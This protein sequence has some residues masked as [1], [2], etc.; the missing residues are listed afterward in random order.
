MTPYEDRSILGRNPIASLTIA[1]VVFGL[2]GFVLTMTAVGS[3]VGIPMMMVALVCGVA[4]I[5]Q[6]RKRSPSQ[7]ATIPEADH[8]RA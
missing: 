7:D 8:R 4:A 2:V 1:A 5:W 6:Y 3:I